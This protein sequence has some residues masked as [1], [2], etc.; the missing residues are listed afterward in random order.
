SLTPGTIPAGTVVDSQFFHS[1]RMASTSALRTATLTFP[2]D[3]IGIA[4]TR[5]TLDNSNMLGASGT[6]YTTGTVNTHG[7]ELASNADGVTVSDLRTVTIRGTTN[8][9]GDDRRL[10]TR[11]NSAPTANAGGPY[12]ANEG[13]PVTLHGVAADPDG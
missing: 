2:T 1:Q 6:D 7:L 12:S 5:T 8:N 11:H 3:V 13:S 9:L 10:I 4:V